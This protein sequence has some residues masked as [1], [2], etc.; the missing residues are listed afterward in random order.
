M[1]RSAQI[2]PTDDDDDV[3][4]IEFLFHRVIRHTLAPHRN[5]QEIWMV[6][7]STKVITVHPSDLNKVHSMIMHFVKT[8]FPPEDKV[9]LP[10]IVAAIVHL[11]RNSIPSVPNGYIQVQRLQGTEIVHHVDDEVTKAYLRNRF[12][13]TK[14]GTCAICLDD[15]EVGRHTSRLPCLH[16]FHGPCILKWLK[17]DLHC[18]LCRYSVTPELAPWF[19]A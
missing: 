15:F 9:Q 5:T 18:P 8:H 16:V 4:N 14:H 12:E 13:A 1:C 19:N 7:Q 6:S 17:I 10:R 11:V 2:P 3:L